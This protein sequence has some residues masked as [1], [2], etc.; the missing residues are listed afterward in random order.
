LYSL[1]FCPFGCDLICNCYLLFSVFM[2]FLFLIC[3]HFF[4]VHRSFYL[5]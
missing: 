4:A 3:L 2:V 1:P 5:L